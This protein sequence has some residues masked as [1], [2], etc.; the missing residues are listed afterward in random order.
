MRLLLAADRVAATLSLPT[1]GEP[2][3]DSDLAELYAYPSTAWVRANFVATVDGAAAGADGKSASINTGADK[4]V[5][6]L[7]RALADVVLVG[8]GT[9]REEGYRRLVAGSRWRHLRQGRDHGAALVVV[10]RRASLPD[11]ALA[12]RERAGSL[13]LVTCSSAPADDI[14]RARA[15]LGTERVLV[16]GDDT[17]DLPAA[18]DHLTQLGA[19]RVLCEGGP[20]L[21]GDLVRSG[22]LDELCLT[23]SPLLVGG[24]HPRISTGP[25]TRL[26]VHPTTLIECDGTLLG[27]WVRDTA[28]SPSAGTP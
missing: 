2:L 18:L 11:C 20:S 8:A 6:G 19:G 5:F 9:V 12:E 22:R 27:R 24:G 28:V 3:T 25:D 14:A 10:S 13:L 17:V 23:L 4:V 26:A 7:L 15:L 16:H 1:P 21:M